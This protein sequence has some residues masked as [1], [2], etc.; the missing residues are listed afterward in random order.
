MDDCCQDRCQGCTISRRDYKDP[1]HAG[2]DVIE[3]ESFHSCSSDGHAAGTTT[4]VVV[5]VGV[6]W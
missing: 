4:A 5:V 3:E 2:C 1:L 6:V